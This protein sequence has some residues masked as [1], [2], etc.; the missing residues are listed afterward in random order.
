M[1]PDKLFTCYLIDDDADDR[2]IFAIAVSEL[3]YPVRLFTAVDGQA[4]LE[5]LSAGTF[6]P[7]LIFLDLNMPR[8]NGQQCL[9]ALKAH[10]V[11]ASIPVIIYSTSSQEQDREETKLLGA[12]G[13][14]TKPSS[15][16]TLIEILTTL[17]SSDVVPH[18]FIS[19]N[20][21]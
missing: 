2:E 16:K 1:D 3:G 20:H 11:Y 17:V 4:G 10:P 6:L 9:R 18:S 7:D 14:L 12:F 19:I 5:Q 15:V 8:M 21:K 13:F